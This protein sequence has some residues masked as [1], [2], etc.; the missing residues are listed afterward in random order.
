MK[1]TFE[2]VEAEIIVLESS[3][4]ITTSGDIGSGGSDD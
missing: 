3:D 2:P 4:V 1:K